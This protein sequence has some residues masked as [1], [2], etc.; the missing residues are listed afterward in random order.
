MTPRWSRLPWGEP[1]QAAPSCVSV[2][3]QRSPL[4]LS[5]APHSIGIMKL[6][7]SGVTSW[8]KRIVLMSQTILRRLC[9]DAKRVAICEHWVLEREIGEKHSEQLDRFS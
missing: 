2:F 3:P 1:L 8:I 5:E 9:I 4:H 6:V 7:M